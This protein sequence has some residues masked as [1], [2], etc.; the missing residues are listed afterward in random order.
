MENSNLLL[1][2]IQSYPSHSFKLFVKDS[3]FA[4]SITPQ[5]YLP[6]FAFSL[7]FLSNNNYYVIITIYYCLEIL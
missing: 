3:F 7:I 6:F 4:S 5:K 2:S 1:F